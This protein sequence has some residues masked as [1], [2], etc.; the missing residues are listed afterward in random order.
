MSCELQYSCS[1]LFEPSSISFLDCSAPKW[2]FINYQEFSH[3]SIYG[4]KNRISTCWT[5]TCG[6]TYVGRVRAWTR[7]MRGRGICQNAT[8]VQLYLLHTEKSVLIF[9]VVVLAITSA[10]VLWLK[11]KGVWWKTI[12]FNWQQQSCSVC[13]NTCICFGGRE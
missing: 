8:Q 2:T 5:I 13:H 7:C 3:I 11:V 6:C 9:W 4:N 1:N 12:N 10:H